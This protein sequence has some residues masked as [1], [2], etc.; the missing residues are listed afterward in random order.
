M[1]FTRELY[2]TEFGINT[3]SLSESEKLVL[4]VFTY[5]ILA[6]NASIMF[7]ICEILLRFFKQKI[8][9]EILYALSVFL[10]VVGIMRTVSIIVY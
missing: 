9:P 5:L 7:I 4:I 8:E 3:D 2:K 1:N 6:I 10:L